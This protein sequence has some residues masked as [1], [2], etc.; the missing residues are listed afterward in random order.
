MTLS[1]ANQDKLFSF[2]RNQ[3]RAL[4]FAGIGLHSFALIQEWK[5]IVDEKMN[6][7]KKN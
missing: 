1:E 2:K 3:R 4:S 6:I 7:N 5:N